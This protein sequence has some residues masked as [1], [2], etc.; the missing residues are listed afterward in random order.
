ML[1]SSDLPFIVPIHDNAQVGKF[2]RVIDARLW[3][4][5]SKTSQL[6]MSIWV[7]QGLLIFTPQLQKN[8]SEPFL[9]P[10]FELDYRYPILTIS[11]HVPSTN[12]SIFI[13]TGICCCPTSK[14][15]ILP[16]SLVPP[17]GTSYTQPS[18]S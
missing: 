18:A 17:N 2:D 3:K 8:N 13:R 6:G 10:S 11:Q 16:P 4:Y 7:Q 5:I 1:S 9:Y 15:R 14:I 12:I